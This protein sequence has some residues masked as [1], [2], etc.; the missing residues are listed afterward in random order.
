MEPG[1]PGGMVKLRRVTLRR[2]LLLN[3]M[4]LL[5]LSPFMPGDSSRLLP[6]VGPITIEDA[7]ELP[8]VSTALPLI[9]RSKE[10]S[11]DMIL[12]MESRSC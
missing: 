5:R 7:G 3:T 10:R 1:D 8:G 4:L 11:M 6:F 2:V 9:E 12:E